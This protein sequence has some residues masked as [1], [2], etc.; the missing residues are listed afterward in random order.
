MDDVHS[1][2]E[3][4]WSRLV[5]DDKARNITLLFGSGEHVESPV[6]VDQFLKACT[7]FSIPN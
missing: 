2:I 4:L 7:V 3:A 1:F 6:D 5:H